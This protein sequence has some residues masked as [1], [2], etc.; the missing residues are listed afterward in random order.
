MPSFLVVSYAYYS[1]GICYE[2]LVWA[3]CQLILLVAA[4]LWVRKYPDEGVV[5][6]YAG[7]DELPVVPRDKSQLLDH[8]ESPLARASS[9]NVPVY[10]MSTE[11]DDGV[12]FEAIHVAT[13]KPVRLH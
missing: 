7:V 12:E 11:D 10:R 9:G 1:V 4:W 2:M 3:V 6:Q 8:F 13:S 5:R